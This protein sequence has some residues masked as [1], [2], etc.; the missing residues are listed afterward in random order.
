M[1][2]IK[3]NTGV[4]ITQ[5]VNGNVKKVISPYW[6]DEKKQSIF[7]RLITKLNG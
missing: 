5:D 3:L 7:N 1:K 6:I 2:T 4:I